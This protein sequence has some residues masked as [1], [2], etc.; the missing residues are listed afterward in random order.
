M[1]AQRRACVLGFPVKHSLS[2]LLHGFWLKKYSIQGAYTAEAVPLGELKGA[3]HRLADEGFAGCNLTLPLKEQ[4]LQLMDENDASSLQAGAVNT[5]VMAEGKLKGFN[6]DGFGFVE[7][8]KSQA[9]DWSGAKTVILGAGGAARGVIAALR[10]AGALK[11]TLVNRTPARAEAVAKDLGLAAE[12]FPWEQRAAALKEAT[13]LINCTSLGMTGAEPLDLDLA[14]L[15]AAATVCDIVYR[16][17]KTPLL[18]AAVRRGNP[19]VEGL[20]MLLHQGRLGFRAWF[21]RDPEVTP[22]LYG[23]M[24]GLAA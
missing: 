19:I 16:P 9:P 10:G 1:T 4:A 20:G 22:E 15:P 17:L 21:G 23:Y 2:P 12:I 14:A 6:S 18:A 13:L 5:V 3:L 8:L 7:S 11:F 24:G